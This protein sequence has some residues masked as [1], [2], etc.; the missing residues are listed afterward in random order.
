MTTVQ[1]EIM[2][3]FYCV[4]SY[5]TVKHIKSDETEVLLSIAVT[6]MYKRSVNIQSL[7]M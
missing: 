2:C 6:V 1:N 4:N 5:M 7:E 3:C